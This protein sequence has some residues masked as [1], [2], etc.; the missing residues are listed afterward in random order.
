MSWYISVF[1]NY[2][3]FSGRARRK[4]YWLFLLINMA[5]MCV[6][7]ILDYVV[8]TH[9][10]TRFGVLGL[11]WLA[12]IVVPSWA[13]GVRRLH[14]SGRSGWWLLVSL[15]PFIGPLAIIVLILLPGTPGENE[16]GRNPR[17]QLALA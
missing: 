1:R 11:L 8:G 12:A 15:V 3:D 13:V 2:D 14:D 6:A 16:Y 5:V 4:E 10:V 7:A 17:P 9:E